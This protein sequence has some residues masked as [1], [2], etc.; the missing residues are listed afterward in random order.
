MAEGQTQIRK[1]CNRSS[2]SGADELRLLALEIRPKK[3][4]FAVF[5]RSTLMDWGVTRYGAAT[6]AMRRIGSLLDLHVPA[7]IVIRRRPRSKHSLTGA[8]ILRSIKRGAQRRSIR[9]LSLD[10]HKIRAFFKQRGCRSKHKT[11]ELLAEWFPELAWRVPPKRKL[12][13]S[14]PYNTL[15][16]DAVATAATFLTA[17]SG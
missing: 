16:F 15:L 1:V 12:W 17:E 3:V 14:E 13:Q 7:V 6:S 9:V 4:G 10:A 5:E 8:S 2:N 11:A